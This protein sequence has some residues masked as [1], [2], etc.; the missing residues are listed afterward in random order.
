MRVEVSGMARMLVVD[1]DPAWRSLYRLEF[2]GRFEVVEA[3]DGLQAL[4]LLERLT[5]DIIVTDLRMPRMDGLSFLR[6]L[7]HRGMRLPVVLCS[8]ML[9]GVEVSIPGVRLAPKSPDLRHLAD[10][11]RSAMPVTTS[12]DP[13]RTDAAR[14][15]RD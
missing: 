13:A 3:T 15:G 8:G 12:S 4:S 10:A 9:E 5:P 11:V 6:Q 2:E 1:D 7:E 14:D